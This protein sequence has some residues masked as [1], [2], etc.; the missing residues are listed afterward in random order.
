VEIAIRGDPAVTASLS[1]VCELI[2][3]FA[4][5]VMKIQTIAGAYVGFNLLRD[6]LYSLHP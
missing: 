5:R 6:Q 2:Q 4:M 3:E 1:T